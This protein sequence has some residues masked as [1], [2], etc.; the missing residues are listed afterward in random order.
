MVQLCLQKIRT[1]QHGEVFFFIFTN[2]RNVENREKWKKVS[3]DRIFAWFFPV[4]HI[5]ISRTCP[6]CFVKIYQGFE[7]SWI[8]FQTLNFSSFKKFKTTSRWLAF[9][10]KLCRPHSRCICNPSQ[11]RFLKHHNIQNFMIHA[12]PPSQNTKITKLGYAPTIP[13][14]IP[15]ATQTFPTS[16][17]RHLWG[18]SPAT[19]SKPWFSFF[20]PHTT[21]SQ[22]Q[23]KTPKSPNLAMHQLHQDRF[24]LFP[25]F[26]HITL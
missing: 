21:K 1:F 20:T 18:L 5:L 19:F 11:P 24:L 17:W 16:L 2:T 12:I 13:R 15:F 8:F 4:H 3:R 26:S 22:N 7:F 23:A 25:N 10:T 9:A 14:L 6:T